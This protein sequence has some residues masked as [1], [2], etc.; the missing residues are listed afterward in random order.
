MK[1]WKK[2]ILIAVISIISLFALAILSLAIA[3]PIV[4]SEYT[5]NKEIECKIPGLAE[6]YVPQG[7]CY[8]EDKDA[9]IFSGYNEENVAIYVVKDGKSA[10]II[11]VNPDGSRTESHGGGVATAGNFVYVTNEET[12]LVYSLSKLLSA[13]DGEEIEVLEE[14]DICVASACAFTDDEYIYFTE[15][16]NGNQ[17]VT[18]PSHEYT[19]PAGDNHHAFV[20]AY[21]LDNM[22]G[23]NSENS[24][25]VISVANMVQGFMKHGDTYAIST[26]W[27]VNTSHLTF[28]KGIK[29]SGTTFSTNGKDIPLYYLDSTCVSKVIPMPAFSEDL[30]VVDGRVIVSFESACNKYIIG[31]FFFANKVISLP[32]EE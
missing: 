9:Y 8:V 5:Q 16:Y 31:K 32:I 1:L 25:F 18:D 7:I 3:K 11:S 21:K 10:E 4:Y 19:T 23:F 27:G 24:E 28:Y 30:D 6:G 17:Y 13:K 22:G 29:D 2:I 12:V 15:F 20:V 14:V 26:S